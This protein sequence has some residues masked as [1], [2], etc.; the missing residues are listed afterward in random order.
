LQLAFSS[1]SAAVGLLNYYS[2]TKLNNFQPGEPGVLAVEETISA[3]STALRQSGRQSS[4]ARTRA[5]N[6]AA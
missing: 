5:V 4:S 3:K 6:F 2:G 1:S